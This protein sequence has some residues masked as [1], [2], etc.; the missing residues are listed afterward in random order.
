M[1]TN[2]QAPSHPTTPTYPHNI[3]QFHPLGEYPISSHRSPRR[4]RSKRHRSTSRRHDKRPVSIPRSPRRRRST[5]RFRRSSRPR[6]SSREFSTSRHA[7]RQPSRATSITLRSASPQ[8]REG[9]HRAQDHQPPRETTNPPATLQPRGTTTHNSPHTTP[10]P[11]HSPTT[12]TN[13]PPTSGNPGDNGK[14]IPIPPTHHIHPSGLTTPNHQLATMILMT[15]PQS[16][17]QHSPPT[18]PH[19]IARRNDH[20]AHRGLINP[21]LLPTSLQ[22]T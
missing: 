21:K 10:T 17:S 20:Q 2:D 6:S 4:S 9:R 12:T 14:I 7:S 13:R 5:R 18:T 15:L 22:D 8:H 19:L 1:P 11:D 16:H 3:S